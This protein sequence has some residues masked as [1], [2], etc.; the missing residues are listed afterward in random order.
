MGELIRRQFKS[1][2]DP[3][4]AKDFIWTISSSYLFPPFYLAC[5]LFQARELVC[6]SSAISRTQQ[7]AQTYADGAKNVLQELPH[8]EAR[9]MLE[10][11]AD[12]VVARKN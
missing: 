2:G 11:L 10:V 8:S 3:E 7:L 5:P 4:K 6:R 1:P 9:D 12:H